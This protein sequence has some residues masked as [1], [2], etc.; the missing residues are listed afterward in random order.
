MRTF[1]PEATTPASMSAVCGAESWHVGD[2]DTEAGRERQDVSDPVG[3]RATRPVEQN[4]RST[5]SPHAPSH[6]AHT[7]RR[8]LPCRQGL[9]SRRQCYR[10]VGR[11]V[12]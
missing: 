2:E 1:S 5:S 9:D 3:P 4:E 8:E 10:V 6:R 12:S 11:Y 7:A